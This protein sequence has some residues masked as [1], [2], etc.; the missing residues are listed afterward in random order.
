M[1]GSSITSLE[2]FIHLASVKI[3]PS[4]LFDYKG[5]RYAV[6]IYG[7][8]VDRYPQDSTRAGNNL[9]EDL[10]FMLELQLDSAGGTYVTDNARI[11]FDASIAWAQRNNSLVAHATAAVR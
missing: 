5:G 9:L 10:G 3:G 4:S 2:C 1:R 11:C 7:L 6:A 8:P